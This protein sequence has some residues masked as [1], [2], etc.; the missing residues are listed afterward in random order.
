MAL[1]HT[2]TDYHAKQALY[3]DL[4]QLYIGQ[5]VSIRVVYSTIG[6]M[7]MGNETVKY[8]ALRFRCALFLPDP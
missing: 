5:I 6:E 2:T 3:A 8:N 1:R 4:P 7:F